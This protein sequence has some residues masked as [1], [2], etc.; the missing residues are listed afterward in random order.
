MQKGNDTL[1]NAINEVLS[2]M[3]AEDYAAQMEE[4]ISL[5]PL[6]S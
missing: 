4:A 2:T 3:S 1:R 6:N 5:Q